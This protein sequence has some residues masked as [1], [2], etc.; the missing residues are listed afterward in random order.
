MLWFSFIISGKKLLA[1][2]CM[3]KITKYTKESIWSSWN[4]FL[5]LQ[6][7]KNL[8]EEEKIKLCCGLNYDKL[9]AK[10]LIHL[11]CNSNFPAC[12]KGTAAVS[13]HSNYRILMKKTTHHVIS[14]GL[15]DQL[16]TS[17]MN[18]IDHQSNEGSCRKPRPTDKVDRKKQTRAANIIKL[19]SISTTVSYNC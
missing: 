2:F 11:A 16:E 15:K 5:F 14:S 7:H 10:S 13:Q 19:S 12:A 18:K 17:Y 6:V 1:P 9:S 8:C 4:D 3:P